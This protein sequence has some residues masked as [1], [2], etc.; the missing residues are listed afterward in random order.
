MLL[1][2]GLLSLFINC[3]CGFLHAQD[4]AVQDSSIYK[5]LRISIFDI[6]VLKQK[7][8]RISLRLQVAN[9]G[10][11]PVSFGKKKQ[12]APES[13]VIEIDTVNLPVILRG[14]EQQLT[15]AVR[16]QKIKLAPG[17]IMDELKLEVN[18]NPNKHAA[19]PGPSEISISGKGCADL[20]FDTAY[21]IEYTDNIM[22]LQYFIRNVGNAPAYLLGTT[23]EPEDNLAVNVYFVMAPNSPAAP[24]SPTAFLSVKAAK[25]SAVCC[26]PGSCCRAK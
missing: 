23:T 12:R 1:R 20:V 5:G 22:R 9:T 14:R 25:R 15:S 26:N 8:E 13:L 16:A 11:L 2:V 4:A 17:D 18:L 21:I 6:E 10:R 19:L 3:C 7:S 24:S